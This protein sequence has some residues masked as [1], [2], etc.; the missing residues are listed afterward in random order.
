MNRNSKYYQIV[1]H[2]PR[3]LYR[4]KYIGQ[5]P[6]TLRSSWEISFVKNYLDINNNIIKW[7]SEIVIPYIYS[8][9]GKRHRYFVDFWIKIK[10]KN[11]EIKE[12][13]IE[14]KPFNQTQPPKTPKRKTSKF[15]DRVA[16]YIK[17][18]DKWKYAESFCKRLREEK[19]RNIHFRILTERDLN[20]RS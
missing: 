13:L 15:N 20:V 1:D 16:N 8:L 7:S 18:Q 6:V 5:R 19:G 17:N 4:E 14:I 9:D 2:Y 10:D 12:H 3:L 11:D